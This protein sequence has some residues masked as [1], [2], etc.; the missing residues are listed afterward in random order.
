MSSESDVIEYTGGIVLYK[1]LE[2]PP[3]GNLAVNFAGG[4]TVLRVQADKPGLW[5]F[6]CTVMSHYYMGMGTTFGFGLNEGLP[7]PNPFNKGNENT[8][9]AVSS[10]M[11]S[12]LMSTMTILAAGI[13][14][15]A[16]N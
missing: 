14:A 7:K 3:I 2:N 5:L 6:H 12:S 9:A 15:I 8:K 1:N 10:A 16:L 11:S 13:I 4:W